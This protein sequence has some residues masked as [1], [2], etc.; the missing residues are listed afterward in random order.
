MLKI[1]NYD[2]I[3]GPKTCSCTDQSKI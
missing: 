2:S 1:T 3:G